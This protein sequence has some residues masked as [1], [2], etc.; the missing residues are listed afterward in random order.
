MDIGATVGVVAFFVMAFV[1]II[2]AV[3][4]IASVSSTESRDGEGEKE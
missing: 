1:A 2:T 4:V 3:V